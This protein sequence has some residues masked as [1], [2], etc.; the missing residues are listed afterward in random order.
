MSIDGVKEAVNYLLRLINGQLMRGGGELSGPVLDGMNDAFFQALKVDRDDCKYLLKEHAP[1]LKQA[2]WDYR[3]AFEAENDVT[4]L[5]D[6]NE[7]IDWL[8]RCLK[9]GQFITLDTYRNDHGGDRSEH[10]PVSETW[11]RGDPVRTEGDV[12]LLVGG[13]FVVGEIYAHRFGFISSAKPWTISNTETARIMERLEF[14]NRHNEEAIKYQIRQR[15]KTWTLKQIGERSRRDLQYFYLRR[16]ADFL[17]VSEL[18]AESSPVREQ[19]LEAIEA[20]PPKQAVLLSKV[21]WYFQKGQVAECYLFLDSISDAIIYYGRHLESSSI[22]AAYDD[23]PEPFHLL[24][25]LD[26]FTRLGKRSVSALNPLDVQLTAEEKA[27]LHKYGI[28]TTVE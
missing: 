22:S 13:L 11:T 17:S 5:N 14:Q 18:L 9:L 4:N 27:I 21:R 20:L 2:Y 24:W 23:L 1:G 28:T 16:Q 25:S 19:L 15:F 7:K 6:M 12:W 8:W 26:Q 3:R 10:I